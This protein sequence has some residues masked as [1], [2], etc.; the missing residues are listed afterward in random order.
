MRCGKKYARMIDDVYYKYA[1]DNFVYRVL[2]RDTT[3]INAKK[4]YFEKYNTLVRDGL[5]LLV[6]YNKFRQIRWLI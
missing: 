2:I 5:V 4:Y 6:C 1:E 3:D